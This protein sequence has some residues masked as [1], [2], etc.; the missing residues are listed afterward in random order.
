MRAVYLFGLKKE[1]LS[2]RALIV[3]LIFSLVSFLIA[4][5]SQSLAIFI[6]GNSPAI[7]TLFGVYAILGFFFSSILF[8]NIITTE[9]KTQTFRYVTPYVSRMKI[10]LA[11]FLLMI[12][13]FV[14][15]T[16]IGMIVLFLGRNQFYVPINSLFNLLIFYAYVE[17]ITLLLSTVS[18]NERFSSLLGI[19]ISVIAPILY[20]VI[21]FKNNIIL[22]LLD[23]ILPF[24]YLES[25]WEIGILIVLV[26]G[27]LYVGEYFFERKDL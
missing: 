9:F 12:S 16:L 6:D 22:D 19:L 14:V 21:Y 7:D 4:N 10:Y 15:I 11:K 5:Y 26:I 17:A 3:G 2:G 23:W 20:A 18:A 1:L 25:T 8:S 27:I 13:Y 24:K